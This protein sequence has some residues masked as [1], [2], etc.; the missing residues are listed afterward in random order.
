MSPAAVTGRPHLQGAVELSLLLPWQV[1][2]V[3]GRAF[4]RVI[5]GPRLP[6]PVAT[7]SLR[8]S[9]PSAPSWM[10]EEFREV[11]VFMAML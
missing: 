6:P 11:Q 5:Q 8:A 1:F 2:L 3:G 7:P 9:E 10:V 4:H